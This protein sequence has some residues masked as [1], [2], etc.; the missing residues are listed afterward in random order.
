[1]LELNFRANWMH[2]SRIYPNIGGRYHNNLSPLEGIY[3]LF[4]VKIHKSIFWGSGPV[5]S[6]KG[7]IGEIITD[8]TEMAESFNQFF[9]K[10][11]E[12]LADLGGFAR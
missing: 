1:M 11:G 4:L 7:E 3:Y 10:V 9:P 5:E 8:A 6:L 2:K 12:S